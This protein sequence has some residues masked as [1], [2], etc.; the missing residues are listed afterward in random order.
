[1]RGAEVTPLTSRSKGLL[2]G[3]EPEDVGVPKGQTGAVLLRRR[4]RHDS[5]AVPEE[6]APSIDGRAVDRVASVV[7][8]RRPV[9]PGGGC[10]DVVA[11]E[12]TQ[13]VVLAARA[14]ISGSAAVHLRERAG[15]RSA[16]LGV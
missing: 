13:Q 3:G 6:Q 4:P 8:N 7:P 1:M 12:L 10:V 15:S 2:R 9:C 16:Y 11:Q 14:R 5:P